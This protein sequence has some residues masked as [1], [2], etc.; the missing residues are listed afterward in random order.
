MNHRTIFGESDS[1]PLA[2][3]YTSKQ[4]PDATN[5]S[6][7][8]KNL[9]IGYFELRIFR[10]NSASVSAPNPIHLHRLAVISERIFLY[11]PDMY[12]K[13][14]GLPANGAM[15]LHLLLLLILSSHSH[16]HIS[17]TAMNPH[18]NPLQGQR[19][20]LIQCRPNGHKSF[21]RQ[22]F[23]GPYPHALADLVKRRKLSATYHMVD[24]ARIFHYYGGPLKGKGEYSAGVA[25]GEI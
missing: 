21:V 25:G 22:I 24:A 7:T 3:L 9:N 19:G 14:V 16:V 5:N 23:P 4:A 12:A 13:T 6:N 1:R 11:T 8:P 10:R 18:E 17:N 15:P 20:H 2:H